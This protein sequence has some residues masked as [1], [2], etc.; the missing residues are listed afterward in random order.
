MLSTISR[1]SSLEQLEEMFKLDLIDVFYWGLYD[2]ELSNLI[3]PT[4]DSVYFHLN[5]MKNRLNL[6]NNEIN[7]MAETMKKKGV[8]KLIEELQSQ[9]SKDVYD[10]AYVI[11]ETFFT[12]FDEEI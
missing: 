9:K 11:L 10:R 4:L 12:T 6:Q 2:K 8:L 5:S 7:I 1:H 3:I